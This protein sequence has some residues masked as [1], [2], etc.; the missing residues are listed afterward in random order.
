MAPRTVRVVFE[1][2]RFWTLI[3]SCQLHILHVVAFTYCCL[4]SPL[5]FI[6]FVD[7]LHVPINILYIM[8]LI[9]FWDIFMSYS[10]FKMV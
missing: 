9:V 10:D 7:I 6:L 4:D 1:H 8:K 2:S 3:G 5:T